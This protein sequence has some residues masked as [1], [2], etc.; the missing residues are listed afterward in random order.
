MTYLDAV[1]TILKAAGQ[2]LHFEEITQR[3]GSEAHLAP[4]SDPRS[5]H[6]FAARFRQDRLFWLPPQH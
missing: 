1:Y 4:E 5:A 6:D 3:A 2:P